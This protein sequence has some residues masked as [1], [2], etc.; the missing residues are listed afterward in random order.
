[1]RALL[2]ARRRGLLALT[3]RAL[4]A[5]VAAGGAAIGLAGVAGALAGEG[6]AEPW[7]LRLFTAWCV[8]APYWWYLEHRLLALE[9]PAARLEF[10]ARQA[11][12]R[13]VWLGFAI[14]MG[15]LIIA[16]AR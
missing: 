7:L 1:L 14:A 2:R 16:R 15:T 12:S 4:Q 3:G 5:A 13:M 8:A 6:A 9:D 10:A 11:H